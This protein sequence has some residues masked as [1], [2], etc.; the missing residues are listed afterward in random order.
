V[1]SLA[2]KCA[3]RAKEMSEAPLL[4]PGRREG[5]KLRLRDP[6]VPKLSCHTYPLL[7]IRLFDAQCSSVKS[8]KGLDMCRSS[9]L[10]TN[11][12]LAAQ[13]RLKA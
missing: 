3:T 12:Q 5:W 10:T 13:S 1:A 7:S 11:P 6:E 8:G 2:M 4:T 9:A